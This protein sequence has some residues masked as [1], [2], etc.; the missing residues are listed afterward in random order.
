M[1]TTNQYRIEIIRDEAIRF[2]THVQRMVML[3]TSDVERSFLNDLITHLM[4][5]QTAC[6]RIL[7]NAD[8]KENKNA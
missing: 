6:N 2:S 4:S 8:L 1:N 3:S 7:L 5:V